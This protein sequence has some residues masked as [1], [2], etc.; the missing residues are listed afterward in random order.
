[1]LKKILGLLVLLIVALAAFIATRPNTYHVERAV[2]IAAP[3][4]V[5]QARLENFREWQS[6][7]PWEGLDPAMKRDF[8]GPESG[9]GARYHWVGN[10]KV[11]EGRMTVQESVPGEKVGILLE[12]IKPFA[13]TNQTTFTLAEQGGSTRVVWNMDGTADFM[14]KA[15]SVMKS[16][17]AMIG[18][19]FEKGLA[20][21]KSVA[22][23]SAAAEAAAETAPVDTAAVH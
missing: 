1:M 8:E 23:S 13:S 19:D 15:M 3:A 5:V 9:V 16:M 18:P 22:E 6:W 4:S 12:F 17:D 14:T 7:S 21:L 20:S 2:E 10:D 11:G